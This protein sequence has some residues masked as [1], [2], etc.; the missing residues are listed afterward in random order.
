MKLTDK[1]I[2]WQG[3][4]TWTLDDAKSLVGPGWGKLIEKIWV[5]LPK[6]ALIE[7]VK[8]K[9]GTLR[10]YVSSVGQDV[11]DVIDAVERESGTICEVCGE[12]GKTRYDM[13]WYMTLCESHYHNTHEYQNRPVSLA[14]KAVTNTDA[15]QSNTKKEGE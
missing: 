11:W 3:K 4:R 8:E 7:Q 5:S 15:G 1:A 10:F 14:P 6:D 13:S 9:Y 2:N 12:P